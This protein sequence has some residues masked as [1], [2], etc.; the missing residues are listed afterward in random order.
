MR[1]TYKIY[2][3]RLVLTCDLQGNRVLLVVDAD[4]DLAAVQPRVAGAQ[5]RQSQAG[6]V[7]VLIV[8]GQCDAALEGLLH[9]QEF[10]QNKRRKHS[11]G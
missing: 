6:V 5:P 9:L 10:S 8:A 3:G 4:H 1:V 11:E 7:A 2:P